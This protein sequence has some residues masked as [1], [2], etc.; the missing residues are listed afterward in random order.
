M[1]VREGR[2][3]EGHALASVLE[4]GREAGRE[5]ASILGRRYWNSKSAQMKTCMVSRGP[6]RGFSGWSS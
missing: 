1:A 6:C 5:A 3:G 4:V 2:A